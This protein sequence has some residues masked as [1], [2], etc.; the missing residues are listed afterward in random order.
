METSIAG[1]VKNIQVS[2]SKPLTPLFEA[3]S[4]SIDAIQESNESNGRIDIEIIR[5]EN[6]LAT[7]AESSID[8]QLADIKSFSLCR[9][10]K[11]SI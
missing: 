3:I 2:L 9:I 11:C 1:R 6:S 8:R 4:N 5:D 10:S 7:G